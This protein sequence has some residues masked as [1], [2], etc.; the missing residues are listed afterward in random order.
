ME[1]LLQIQCV[2]ALC[3][4]FYFYS[5]FPD[6]SLFNFLLTGRIQG[7]QNIR[8]IALLKVEN[9]YQRHPKCS[10]ILLQNSPRDTFLKGN[11]FIS[12]NSQLSF[13]QCVQLLSWFIVEDNWVVVQLSLTNKW[14]CEKFI[15]AMNVYNN[16]FTYNSGSAWH[17][18]FSAKWKLLLVFILLYLQ[19]YLPS[20]A[21]RIETLGMMDLC[22]IKVYSFLDQTWK[23]LTWR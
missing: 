13:E 9:L 23:L 19:Q 8:H 7:R 3:I 12:M 15:N 10:P 11:S 6:S 1:N 17:N 20:Y 14:L 18:L 22:V 2:T 4:H 5:A 16:A 21:K